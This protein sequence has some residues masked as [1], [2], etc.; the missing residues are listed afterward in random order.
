MKLITPKRMKEWEGGIFSKYGVPSFL[1]MEQAGASL[2]YFIV[3]DMKFERNKK[4]AV[5]SGK[6]NNGGDGIVCARYLKEAG[7]DVVVFTLFED[8]PRG[9][10][11]LLN[12]KF[13][14]DS[15]GRIFRVS[16]ENLDLFRDELDKYDLIVDA[17]LGI[18]VERDLD[19]LYK[20]VVN[21]VNEKRAIV[22]SVDTPTGINL[23]NGKILGE[24]VKAD[25]TLTFGIPKIGLY[26]Y[27]GRYYAGN[28]VLKRVGFPKK[29]IDECE[30]EDYLIDRDLIMGI[31]PGRVPWGHK[32]TFGKVLTISG[33]R[34]FTGAA[35]FTSLSVLK[36][37][38][39][40]SYLALPKSLDT[41]I[42]ALTPEVI[43]YPIEEK[44]GHISYSAYEEL[45]EK[46]QDVDALAVGPGLGLSE[47]VKRIINDLIQNVDKP[48]VLDA[49]GI[50]VLK[51]NLKVISN[52]EA[53]LVITPHPGEM[54]RLLGLSPVK[55]EEDRIYISREF[56][57]EYKNIVLVLKGGT[58]LI[59]KN[60]ILYYNITGNSGMA[61]GGSGDILT[62]IIASFMGRGIPPLESAILGVYIHGL[63]GDMAASYKGESGITAT[64][65]LAYL[66]YVLKNIEEEKR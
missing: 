29:D 26:T 6:G 58:T 43:T 27:P 32:G 45:L 41:Q 28:V 3:E 11:A 25:Y 64:D 1:F 40:L 10:D 5:I 60:G 19:G 9:E 66:P 37:G 23:S 8:L 4:I 30:V 61:T 34:G 59:A 48:I 55:V 36:A 35:Y 7:Y 20:D 33:S 44:D 49:D 2:F 62:G 16:F 57:K 38:S 65:I 14:R 18:G 21:I 39:G 51:D 22:L 13:Y 50:N 46:I 54:G 12:F 56:S 52:R 42:K 17:I 63:S 47:G 53:P 24:A 15:G 31:F